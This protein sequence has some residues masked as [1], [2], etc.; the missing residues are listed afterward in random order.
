M[1]EETIQTQER[2]MDIAQPRCETGMR[3]REKPRRT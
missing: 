1:W 3:I 2:K